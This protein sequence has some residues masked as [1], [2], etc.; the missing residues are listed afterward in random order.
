MTQVPSSP[1][2]LTCYKAIE[3][4]YRKMVEVDNKQYRLEILDTAGTEQFTAMRDMYIKN[5]DGF[6]LVYAINIAN[7]LNELKEIYRVITQVK[8]RDNI[9]ILVVANKSDLESMRY[10]DTWNR[11]I[12]RKISTKEGEEVAKECKAAFMEASALRN[13][14]IDNIFHQITRKV[15]KFMPPPKLPKKKAKHCSI[16]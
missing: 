7:S 2:F 15:A 13:L 9:P 3:D 16:V 8:E 14:N 12:L 4:V 11:L 5:C 10:Y 6:V 1:C